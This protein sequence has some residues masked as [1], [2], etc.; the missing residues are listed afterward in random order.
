MKLL[1]MKIMAIVVLIKMVT[2]MIMM[3]TMTYM[4]AIWSTSAW[5]FP[6]PHSG[7][8]RIHTV[9]PK[10]NPSPTHIQPAYNQTPADR[11]A[12]SNKMPT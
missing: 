9:Q 2:A 12:Q 4:V 8:H 3:V 7:F 6:C 11:P 5:H 1:N 10:S